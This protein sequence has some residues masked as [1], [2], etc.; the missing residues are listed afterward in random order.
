MFEQLSFQSIKGFARFCDLV[1]MDLQ[2]IVASGVR[3]VHL[4][5]DESLMIRCDGFWCVF[6][7]FVV[8]GD[9]RREMCRQQAPLI[10]I[11]IEV[12]PVVASCRCVGCLM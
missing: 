10:S 7:K 8:F 1:V 6:L 5:P 9:R 12:G 3:V 2:L 4:R 11:P